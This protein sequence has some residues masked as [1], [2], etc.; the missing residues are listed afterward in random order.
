MMTPSTVEREIRRDAAPACQRAGIV[1]NACKRLILW[2]LG[3]TVKRE[4]VLLCNNITDFTRKVS[5]KIP[6]ALNAR[7][8]P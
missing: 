4:F 7:A 5:E 3:Y 1:V 2:R 8:E 6:Q